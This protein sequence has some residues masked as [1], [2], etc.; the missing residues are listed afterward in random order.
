[1]LLE[2]SSMLERASPD[3]RLAETL[4]DFEILGTGTE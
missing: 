3:G 4:L 1:V 2:I